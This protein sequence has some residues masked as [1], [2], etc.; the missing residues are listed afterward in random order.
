[1]DMDKGRFFSAI[2]ESL[3]DGSMNKDQV[4]GCEIILELFEKSDQRFSAY[5]LGTA[6]LE[7]GSTMQPIKEI[8]GTAY[9]TRMYDI[10]GERSNLARVN[11]NVSVG[12]GARYAGRGYVQ[13]TWRDNYAKAAKVV[14]VD[15]V[16]YPDLAMRPDI[17]AKIMYHGMTIGWFTGKKLSDY[18]KG[19]K[20]D[21]INA[22]RIING[23][24]RAQEIA[25]YSKLFYSAIIAANADTDEAVAPVN[26]KPFL[27]K[28]TALGGGLST[29]T[30]LIQT[31][32]MATHEAERQISTGTIFGYTLGM[33][34][35]LGGLIALYAAWDDAGRPLPWSKS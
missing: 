26:S 7:T 33:I 21:W 22:R 11:G 34:A 19:G 4:K 29:V 16:K 35:I 20:S 9:F 1:M 17:A 6:Y 2:R 25:R 10:T 27:E 13:L 8:G 5:A 24:D 14:G 18:F 28:R 30:G 31:A 15:L 12:D 23:T 32:E 3:F